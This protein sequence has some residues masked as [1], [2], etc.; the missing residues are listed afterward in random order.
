MASQKPLTDKQLEII[1]LLSQGLSYQQ[2]TDKTGVP[3]PT[4][5]RWAKLSQ[6]QA[7]VAELQKSRIEI[8]HKSANPS[9]DNLQKQLQESQ[10]RE[11]QYVRTA[12]AFA[13]ECS[14]LALKLI[15]KAPSIL[16]SEP[17][18]P[19]ILATLLPNLVKCSNDSFRLGSDLEDKIFALEEM[20]KRLDAWK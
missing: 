16:E 14:K 9:L 11:I 10:E 7:E 20:S 2:I 17:L 4:V 18:S 1:P 12:E 5:A 3:K 6:V 15:E 13:F 19:R 8:C